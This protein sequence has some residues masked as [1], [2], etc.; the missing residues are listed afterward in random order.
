MRLLKDVLHVMQT[1]FVIPEE[2]ARQLL[3]RP[4]MPYAFFGRCL[5]QLGALKYR[6]L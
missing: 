2:S 4:F 1:T 6:N 5:M 3:P